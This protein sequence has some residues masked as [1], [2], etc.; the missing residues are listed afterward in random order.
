MRKAALIAA[1]GTA[2]ALGVVA[3]AFA[4]SSVDSQGNN[5]QV[6]GVPLSD[7]TAVFPTNKQNEPTIAVN[8]TNLS[9]LIAGSNDE[10]R[11][12]PCGPGLVRGSLAPANDCSFF[13]NVGTSGVYTSSDGGTTW[14]NNGL[15]PGFSDT[16]G[17]LVSDG[18][19][20]IVY[21]PAPGPSG[22]FATARSTDSYANST[23]A[24]YASLASYSGGAAGGNQA[25]E[26][27]TV[28]T[29]ADDGL[30][31]SAP[32]VAVGG[33]GFKFN[34]K[35][36]LWADNNP[37][38]PYFGR[39]YLSWTQFRGSFR[40]GN[41]EP[42]RFTYSDDGGKTWSTEKQLSAA[43][44]NGTVGGRQGSEI[45]TGPNGAVYVVWEDGDG[46]GAKQSAAVSTNGGATFSRPV[47][48][49]RVVDLR[50]PVPGAN[51]RDSSFPSIAVDQATG[52]VYVAWADAASGQ[53]EIKLTKSA[54]GGKTWSSPQ[55][56]SKAADGY[57]FFQGLD[58]VPGR[59][60]VAYQA[61][62]AVDPG[63]Y[64][65]G[66]ATIDSYYVS[67]SDGFAASTRISSASSDPAASAQ[68]NLARQ[69]WGDYNTLV[70]TNTR[71]WFIYTDSRSGV[72]CPA[73]DAYQHGLD[74]SGPALPKPAPGSSCPSQFG[75][76]DA[77]V[78][79]ITP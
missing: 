37:A 18:D 46:G 12:P 14:T 32:V 36:S 59:V 30:T 35:E 17:S 64:G 70:S 67:S 50:D 76:T 57:A 5:P 9:R 16:G 4:V 42:I 6:A 7:T 55:V 25:P 21:G 40:T 56:I 24:Y 29:S 72:G 48:V 62:K 71:A 1:L 22:S 78:S 63:T 33:H 52:T 34:D 47:D 41:A 75:N 8:P 61:L 77:F 26:L 2:T 66:N 38:S 31:W 39:V 79:I 43:H 51:F 23:R 74:G 65:T 68:N 13:P 60:D 28:S 69:F 10:Q 54:S 53:G 19:P 44:N 58:V 45:A 27:L 20:V 49:A 11:Q 3:A 15:L 73:V